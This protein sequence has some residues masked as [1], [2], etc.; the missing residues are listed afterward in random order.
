MWKRKPFFRSVWKSSLKTKLLLRFAAVIL[1]I[2][3]VSIAA[4]WALRGI[5]NQMQIMVETTVIA[6][7]IIAPSLEI[8]DLIRN[9]YFNKQETD[10]KRI[11]ESLAII[12]ENMALLAKNIMTRMDWTVYIPWRR[13]SL[14]IRK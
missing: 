9:Y 4:H 7:N 10:R 13:S 11:Q 14:L 12:N 3:G 6:N 5:I 8:P 2:G 1:V